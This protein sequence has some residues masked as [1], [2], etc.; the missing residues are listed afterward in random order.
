MTGIDGS[1]PP[2]TGSRTEQRRE[3]ERA[4]RAARS[5]NAIWRAWWFYPLVAGI[6]LS[7]VMGVASLG[8]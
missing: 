8:A 5:E 1:S 2:A 6:L 4:S 3:N 7:A